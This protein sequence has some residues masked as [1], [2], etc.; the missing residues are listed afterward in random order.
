MKKLRSYKGVWYAPVLG[1]W[2]YGGAKYP[3]AASV[4]TSVPYFT[5][6]DHAELMRLMADP[7]EK[8]PRLEDVIESAYDEWRGG[9]SRAG[10]WFKE[11]IAKRIRE[12]FPHI[13]G[14]GA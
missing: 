6:N 1:W 7:Y 8:V 13:D 4:I 10:Y 5:D 2:H 12:A 11:L 3:S 9:Y 14:E